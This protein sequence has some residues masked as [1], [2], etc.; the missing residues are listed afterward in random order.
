MR[1]S[2]ASVQGWTVDKPRNP[3]ADF[4][5]IYARKARKRGGLSFG[6]FSLAT[7]RKVTRPPKEDES[8]CFGLFFCRLGG[9][10]S[11]KWW[12]PRRQRRGSSFV[13]FCK[14]FIDSA[15]LFFHSRSC[16]SFCASLKY[17]TAFERCGAA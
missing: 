7:Q 16:A 8:F 4:P 11:E 9:G 17:M 2:L 14:I 5:G 12:A 13:V 15:F 1:T 10:V 6:Y 3:H